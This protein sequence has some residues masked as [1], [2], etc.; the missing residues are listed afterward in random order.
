MDVGLDYL[1]LRRS[2][3]TLS[4]G[5][6][7]RIRLAT[8]I[9]SR[10]MGVLYVLDEPSIV[11]HPRDN[12]RL[13]S[14]LENLRDLGNTVLVVEHDDD[15]IRTADWIVDLGPGAGE[16]GG[17]IVAEGTVKDIIKSKRSITGS[18]LSGKLQVP[19]PKTRRTGNGH[20]LRILGG[21]VVIR[22]KIPYQSAFNP[23]Y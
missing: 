15:T 20:L 13:L 6:A 23:S 12:S 7:Q 19:L 17:E 5:E 8:Q 1:T 4:G 22:M 21:I 14:T 18:Y 11:L 9:G 16:H 3:V 10:L 2:A